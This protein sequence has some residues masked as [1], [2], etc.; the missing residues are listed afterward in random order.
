MIDGLLQN[1]LPFSQL[2]VVNLPRVSS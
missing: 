2:T 1:P